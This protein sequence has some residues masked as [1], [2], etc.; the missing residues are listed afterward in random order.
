MARVAK[1]SRRP[2]DV[3]DGFVALLLAMTTTE[4]DSE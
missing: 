3:L 2:G 4:Q 1:Q